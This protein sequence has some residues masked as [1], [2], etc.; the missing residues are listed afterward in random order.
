MVLV[1]RQVLVVLALRVVL[2]VLALLAPLVVL[3]ILAVLVALEVLELRL[4]EPV[5]ELVLVH[6]PTPPLGRLLHSVVI[7]PGVEGTEYELCG[8]T[9]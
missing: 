3:A 1:L 6:Q 9:S 5:E 8:L 4:E 2:G 7:F